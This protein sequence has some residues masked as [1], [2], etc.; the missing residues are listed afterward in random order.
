MSPLEQYISEREAQLKKGQNLT[1]VLTKFVGSG[2]R[3]L[4][5]H[6]QTTFFIESRLGRHRNIATILVPYIYN[7]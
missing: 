6:N 1:V 3:D 4:I 5:F 2:W 7:Q